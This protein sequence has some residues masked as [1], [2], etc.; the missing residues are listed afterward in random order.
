MLKVRVVGIAMSLAVIGGGLTACS[1]SRW[2]EH[3]ATDTKVSDRFC[4]QGTPG[5]EWESGSDKKKSKKKKKKS[6]LHE[7]VLPG[8][9]DL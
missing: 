7:F 8:H 4:K 9:R 6:S 2:C 3:D 1:E 5:Y